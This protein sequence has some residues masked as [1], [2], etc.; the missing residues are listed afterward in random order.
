MTRTTGR[1]AARK[2]NNKLEAIWD[3]LLSRQ[4]K[5]IRSA[6]ASLGASEQQVVLPT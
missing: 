3:D 2:P 5:R 1:A 6:F 4:P